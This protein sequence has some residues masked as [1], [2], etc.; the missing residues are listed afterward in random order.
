MKLKLDAEGHVV[1]QDG[2]PVY[3]AD[4]GKELAFDAK[5]MHDKIIELGRESAGHRTRANDAES[6]LKAFDGIEDPAAA[7]EAIKTVKNLDQKKLVDAGQVEVVKAEAIKAVEEKY[8]P[9]VAER[10]RL[11]AD[12]KTEKLGN[13]F[14]RSKFVTD[15]FAIPADMVQSH[16]GSFF[17]VKEG[18]TVAK[19]RSGNPI[20]SR[21][22]PG[23]LADFDEALEQL[24]EQYP[25]KDMILKGTQQNGGGAKPPQGGDH[26]PG[27]PKSWG[28]AKTPQEKAAY[29][30][31]HPEQ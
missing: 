17:D 7:R 25:N 28:E 10:D 1:L 4:D 21:A 23:E 22:R 26:K 5:Q 8:A 31:A 20:Y 2:K 30:A 27:T 29:I 15:K 24:V 12:N 14:S 16:F 3:T 18:K 9:V 11:L 6:K 13:A 19:D